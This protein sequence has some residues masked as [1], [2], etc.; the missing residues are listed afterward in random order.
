[1]EELIKQLVVIEKYR[2][3]AEY[4]KRYQEIVM[5]IPAYVRKLAPPSG[6]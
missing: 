1:M 4:T 6:L 5:R 2:L 3:A